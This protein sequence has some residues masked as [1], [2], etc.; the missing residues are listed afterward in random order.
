M[1]DI[2]I[3]KVLRLFRREQCLDNWKGLDNMIINEY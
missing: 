2:I 1:W 3:S